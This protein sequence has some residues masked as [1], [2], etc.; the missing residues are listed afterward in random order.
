MNKK[1]SFDFD[2][3]IDRKDIQR[4]AKELISEGYDV[5]IV[6]SRINTESALERGWYWVEKNNQE[7]YD[8]AE[9]VGIPR[10]KI[11][12]TEHVDKIE[13]LFGKNFLFHIDDDVDELMA[14]IKSGDPCKVVNSDHSDWLIHCKEIING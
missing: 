2:S 14:I 5:W 9:E 6:T 10:D 12:F 1:V 3:T 8:V 11:V 13:Y 7:L 4:Y